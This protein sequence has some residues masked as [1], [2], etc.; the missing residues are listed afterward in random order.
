M[1]KLL[2]IAALIAVFTNNT[3][4]QITGQQIAFDAGVLASG[5]AYHYA[6]N[7]N[8]DDKIL[9]YYVGYFGTNTLHY[10]FQKTSLS[11]PVKQI[12]PLVIM[13]IAA[14]VKEA[15]DRH[16]SQGDVIATM[17]GCYLSIVR[18]SIKF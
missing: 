2:F 11:E 3:S 9:H 17:A 18:C 1:K 7:G 15:T 5:I 4:G 6:D 8:H 16:A 12:L 10:L 13:T 14:G